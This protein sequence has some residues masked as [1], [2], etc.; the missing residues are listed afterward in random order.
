MKFRKKPVEIEAV[1][2]FGFDK[3]PD[4]LFPECFQGIIRK[5]PAIKSLCIGLSLSLGMGEFKNPPGNYGWVKTLE[6]GH[7]ISYG[8]YLIKGVKGEFYPCKPDIFKL[9]YEEC[10][11]N[12]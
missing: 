11:P 3:T 12:E 4:N 10:D 7:V 8:D 2:W 5:L 6:G 9:T 1:R